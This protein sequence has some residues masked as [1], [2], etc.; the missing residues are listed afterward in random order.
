MAKST[1]LGTAMTF[2]AADLPPLK[3]Q[4]PSFSGSPAPAALPA[5]PAWPLPAL[6]ALLALPASTVSTVLTASTALTVLLALAASMAFFRGAGVACPFGA[7]LSCSSEG[8]ASPASASSAAASAASMAASLPARTCAALRL[9][10]VCAKRMVAAVVF[11]ATVLWRTPMTC[12]IV[13]SSFTRTVL[14]WSQVLA[15]SWH[16][17]A[18]F[19]RYSWSSTSVAATVVSCRLSFAICS[20]RCALRFLALSSPASF[21]SI[22]ASFSCLKM[23]WSFAADTSASTSSDFLSVKSLRS[24]STVS[25]MLSEW[26]R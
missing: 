18:S 20:C 19:L 13:V 24:F 26:K 8:A 17:W 23:V 6:P 21:S 10:P 16:I 11:S 12:V 22:S 2:R 1:M 4:Q 9:T 3:L 5:L 7:G 14:R 15:L 25:M